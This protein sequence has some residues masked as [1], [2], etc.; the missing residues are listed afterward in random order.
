MNLVLNSYG[1]TLQKENN[2]FVISTADGKQSIPPE[3]VSSIS[4]SKAA[5][6]TSDAVLLAIKHQ[7]DILFVND[8]GMPEGRVWSIKYGSISNL[9]RAQ[10]DFMYSPAVIP[11]VKELLEEKINGQVAL[12]LA[13]QP[14]PDKLPDYNL[15]RFAINS[16]EDYKN[17]IRQCT[18]E[19]IS[20]VAASFRG[21][22]GAA[23]KKYFSVISALLPN[24]YKF[25]S[26]S[27][28]PATDVFNAMLNYAY[29]ILYGKVEGALIK[30][31]LDPYAGIFHRDEYNRP[32]LVFDVIEKYRVWMDYVVIQLCLQS[33]LPDD[34]FVIGA[35][36]SGWRLEALGKRILIQSVN[37]Y[38]SEIVSM[39]GLD[40]SRITHIDLHA[41]QLAQ[42]FNKNS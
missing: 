3:K 9:R 8:Q 7:V 35:D 11:W 40:R 29:G 32:A 12:L 19:T 37:D 27:R 14:P 6:I 13:L 22:E 33:A 17:K 4:I 23:S 36:N 18:G 41:Q 30:A 31:G 10:L 5:R 24:Q 20:D 16:M 28:Q 2:L 21:W 25:E 15:V 26:R 1:A 38:L 42:F 39:E 34:C